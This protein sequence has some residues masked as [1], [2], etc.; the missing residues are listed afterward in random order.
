MYS[1]YQVET[2]FGIVNVTPTD[3]NHIHVSAGSSGKGRLT[4]GKDTYYVSAHFDQG[5]KMVLSSAP[6]ISRPQDDFNGAPKSFKAKI[7]AEIVEK[8]SAWLKANPHVLIQA[9][10]D[11]LERDFERAQEEQRKAHEAYSKSVE[12]T[13]RAKDALNAFNLAHK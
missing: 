3:A 6:S 9:E 2:K 4:M 10:R 13:I 1:T 8:V 5:E 12:E 11:R 7:V